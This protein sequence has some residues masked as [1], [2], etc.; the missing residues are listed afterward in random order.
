MTNMTITQMRDYLAAEYRS[1]DRSSGQGEHPQMP[2]WA[3]RHV[4]ERRTGRTLT[5]FPAGMRVLSLADLR[6]LKKP[7]QASA[8]VV[9]GLAT[10]SEREAMQRKLRI[11]SIALLQ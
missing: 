10:V 3:V 7:A 11:A 9:E 5:P 8:Q 4:F 1:S 2:D 6:S